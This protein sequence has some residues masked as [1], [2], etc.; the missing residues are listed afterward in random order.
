MPFSYSLFSDLAKAAS[1]KYQKVALIYGNS[2]LFIK[3]ANYFKQGIEASKIA[4]EGK[5]L[6]GS[7]YK[8]EVTKMLTQNPD[9]TTVI[10]SEEDGVRFLNT[11]KEQ[12]QNK[13]INIIC[14]ANMELAIN[15]Y[16]KAVGKNLLEGC[17]STML[18]AANFPEFTNEFKKQFGTD[19][20]FGSDYAYDAANIIQKISSLPYQEQINYL[21]NL[22]Y[23]GA[24][25]EIVFDQNGT[26]QGASELHVLR[27]GKFIKANN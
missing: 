4:Y 17:I 10:L 15:Q 16:L 26:R 18:P 23:N 8:T 3:N 6:S 13:K 21:K 14:D 22:S 9:A 12:K 7:D 20:Q 25:G 24:S 27:D 11:L 1:A 2:D 5:L 19:P